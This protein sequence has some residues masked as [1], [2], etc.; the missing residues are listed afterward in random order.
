[1]DE[2]FT[3]VSPIK[4]TEPDICVEVRVC[5]AELSVA[6]GSDHVTMAEGRPLSVPWLIL[7]GMLVITGFS[8]SVH[9]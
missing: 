3:T 6:I 9:K 7:V 2:Y 5:V 4:N 1:M 8:I